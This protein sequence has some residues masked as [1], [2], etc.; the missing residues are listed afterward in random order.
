MSEAIGGVEDSAVRR[1]D[2]LLLARIVVDGYALM[3]A[4]TLAGDKAAV[5]EANE[6]A[7]LAIGGVREVDRAIVGHVRIA[8]DGAG[9]R[10]RRGWRWLR[11]LLCRLRS[12]RGLRAPGRRRVSGLLWAGALSRRGRGP[13]TGSGRARAVG[14]GGRGR[15]QRRFLEALREMGKADASYGG[16]ASHRAACGDKLDYST[17]V[18]QAGLL[19]RSSFRQAHWGALPE[20]AGS[21]RVGIRAMTGPPCEG[22]DA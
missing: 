4:G 1:A 10:W 17:A 9:V 15:G 20:G 14:G 6:Q 22:I 12:W 21:G 8:D 13:L 2:D 18:L 7:A 3:G 16:N 11:R 5:G 19:A